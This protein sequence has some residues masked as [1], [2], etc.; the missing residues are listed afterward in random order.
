MIHPTPGDAKRVCHTS[1]ATTDNTASHKTLLPG[2]GM[3]QSPVDQTWASPDLA[4]VPGRR[5]WGT[6]AQEDLAWGPRRG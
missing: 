2:T 3:R 5:V 6:M 1:Q 4:P